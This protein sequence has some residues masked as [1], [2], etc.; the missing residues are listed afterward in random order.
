MSL[1]SPQ[2]NPP[3]AAAAGRSVPLRSAAAAKRMRWLVIALLALGLILT[4]LFGLRAMRSFTKFRDM[5]GRPPLADI[6]GVRPWMTLGMVAD[7]FEIDEDRLYEEMHIARDGNSKRSLLELEKRY[8]DDDRREF[9]RRLEL[10]VTRLTMPPPH[11]GP[12]PPGADGEHAPPD[13]QNAPAAPATPT[14]G[15]TP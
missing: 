5:R 13:A 12:P 6:S 10:A 7:L 9:R 1:E 14:A 2:I 8:G 4:V 15:V 3:P 11:E